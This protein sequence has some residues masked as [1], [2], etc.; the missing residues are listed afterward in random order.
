MT[1]AEFIFIVLYNG[2]YRDHQL[3]HYEDAVLPVQEFPSWR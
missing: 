1:D 3:F 2:Q